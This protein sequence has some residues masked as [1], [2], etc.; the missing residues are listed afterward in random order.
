L[1]EEKGK[2]ELETKTK[3]IFQLFAAKSAILS[4]PDPALNYPKL[5][6]GTINIGLFRKVRKVV[7]KFWRS[8]VLVL[9]FY[10][11]LERSFEILYICMFFSQFSKVNLV[12]KE[13]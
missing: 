6:V 13:D 10:V 11:S 1:Y 5:N 2:A 7:R 4:D 12:K 8:D 3:I 9:P